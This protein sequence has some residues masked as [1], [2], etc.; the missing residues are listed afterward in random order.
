MQV[1]TRLSKMNPGSKEYAKF[2]QKTIW[3][4]IRKFHKHKFTNLLNNLF[5]N[6]PNKEVIIAEL[7]SVR[8]R[9]AKSAGQ[10]FDL[11]SELVN[12]FNRLNH[13]T[14]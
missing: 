8:D 10:P 2:L 11:N 3:S 4:R 12:V 14:V 13:G 7:L 1:V 5:G 9:L 6:H